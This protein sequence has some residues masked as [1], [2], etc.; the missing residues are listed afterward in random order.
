[1]DV[2]TPTADCL[3]LVHD[4][5]M[6]VLM[7][8]H[9]RSTLSHQEVQIFSP[10]TVH[11]GTVNIIEV[12]CQN[13]HEWWNKYLRENLFPNWNYLKAVTTNEKQGAS[14]SDI[15]CTV[16]WLLKQ[17]RILG[18]TKD[19][20]EQILAMVF[21]NYKSLDES[22]FSGLMDIFRPATGI[23]APALEP[24][25][26][27]YTLLHDILSPEAQTNLCHYFQVNKIGMFFIPFLALKRDSSFLSYN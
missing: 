6:P 13:F 10:S 11:S 12:H 9:S 16:Y 20:I 23:A 7:K 8:G 2:A 22:S 26:K 15:P 5:L 14:C 25:V 18:E 3:N 1:M 4:L 17:N 19:Q 27:L 21:E 24:A